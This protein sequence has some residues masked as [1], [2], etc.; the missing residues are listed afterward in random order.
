M[1]FSSHRVKCDCLT[2]TNF[3]WAKRTNWIKTSDYIC[4]FHKQL[5]SRTSVIEK[6]QTWN[7]IL[8]SEMILLRLLAMIGMI[9]LQ[10]K[11]LICDC[12]S[13]IK[14]KKRN[15]ETAFSAII[16]YSREGSQDGKHF[17]YRHVNLIALAVEMIEMKLFNLY[18]SCFV[19]WNIFQFRCSNRSCQKGFFH[20]YSVKA[21]KEI[22]EM[23][24]EC[25][26]DCLES[27]Y[28]VTSSET[29]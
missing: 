14:P 1:T 5:D 10:T 9:S 2:F 26:D 12:G 22:P 13:Q 15:S 21:N 20:G 27:E 6:C 28:L 25:H 11:K 17:E 4:T 3:S 23:L 18:L 24:Y 16:I 29:W 19:V 8:F 7:M